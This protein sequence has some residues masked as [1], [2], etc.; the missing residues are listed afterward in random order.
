MPFSIG[1][2]IHWFTNGQHWSGPDGIPIRIGQHLF[3]SAVAVA[4]AILVAL[5]IGLA[6]GH[7][8]RG[9]FLAVSVANIGRAVPSFAVLVLVFAFMARLAPGIAYG[10]GPGVITLLLLGIPPILTNTIVGIQNVDTDTVEAARGMGMRER[11]ILLRLE[12][13][14]ASGLILGGIRTAVLQIVATATLIA[15][16]G[17][18]GLGRYI[19][20]GTAQGDTTMTVA[21]AVLVALLAIVTELAMGYAQRLLTPRTSSTARKRARHEPREFGPQPRLGDI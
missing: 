4:A 11:D 13:P 5:P 9:E 8:R 19:I 14:L 7:R 20:D 12:L 1:N 16:I 15:L 10:F 21:G 6:I 2:L 17:G 3:I 18:G